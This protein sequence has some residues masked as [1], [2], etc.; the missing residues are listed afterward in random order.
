MTTEIDWRLIGQMY[1]CIGQYPSFPPQSSLRRLCLQ[2]TSLACK[3]AAPVSR[4]V[5]T[6]GT[7]YAYITAQ[8][9]SVGMK[10]KRNRESLRLLKKGTQSV[11]PV[12]F[13]PHPYHSAGGFSAPKDGTWGWDGGLVLL[14]TPERIGPCSWAADD[15]YPADR[16]PSAGGRCHCV[17]KLFTGE[18]LPLTNVSFRAPCSV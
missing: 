3:M 2:M 14:S 5:G 16:G 1:R 15:S 11:Q 12:H 10:G 8:G 13:S 7:V 4:N 6:D 9:P 18:S 17:W